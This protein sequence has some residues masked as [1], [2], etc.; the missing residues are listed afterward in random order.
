MAQ[1]AIAHAHFETIHPFPDGNGRTGRALIH[2]LLRSKGVIEHVTV[3]VSAGLLVDTEGYFRSLDAYRQGDAEQVVR[4]LC[5][6]VLLATA[7]ARHLVGD[8]AQLLADWQG[9]LKVRSD[10]VVW[11]LLTGLPGQPVVNAEFV[12]SR[13]AVSDVAAQRAPGSTGSGRDPA[14]VHGKAALPALG[15]GRSDRAS[16]SVRGQDWPAP[17]AR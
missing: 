17:R 2:A 13:F 15:C 7:N 9:Q 3:P 16:G 14:Q 11:R 12:A 4:V 1:V 6:A 8:L 10:S 5:E